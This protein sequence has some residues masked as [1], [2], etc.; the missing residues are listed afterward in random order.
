MAKNN[1]QQGRQANASKPK[2]A[3]AQPA[4]PSSVGRPLTGLDLVVDKSKSALGF[5]ELRELWRNAI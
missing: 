5:A 4:R 1:Q 2:A 3:A